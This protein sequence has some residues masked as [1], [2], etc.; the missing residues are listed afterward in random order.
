VA[1]MLE[2]ARTLPEGPPR[3]AQYFVA[4]STEEPPYFGT[5]QMG[6]WFFAEKL[7]ADGVAVSLAVVLD[8]VGYFT[9]EP[10]SQRMP[11]DALSWLYPDE[12]NFIAVAANPSNGVPIRRVKQAMM[13]VRELE[14]HSFRAP[15]WIKGVDWS[16]HRSFWAHELPA[17]L[18]TDTSFYRNPNYHTAGDTPNTL[19]Y[20]GMVKVVKSLHGV[21]WNS[22]GAP[23]AAA[24]P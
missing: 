6:S 17:V 23:E 13:A 19:D 22:G 1:A 14:V 20:E 5:E 16:D 11:L 2:L 15:N 7:V 9:D 8:M 10:G 24:E 12:G 18:V 3:F 4:F 21:L